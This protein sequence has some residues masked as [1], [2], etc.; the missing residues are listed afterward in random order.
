MNFSQY[1]ILTDLDGTFLHHGTPVPRNIEA[2]R[3]FCEGGGLFSI[4]TGRTHYTV[5]TPLP[6]I[7]ALINLPAVVC[8]GAYLYDYKTGTVLDECFIS[9]S[10]CDELVAFIE[11]H[12]ADVPCRLS[13]PGGIRTPALIG[14][15][16]SDVA[17]NKFGKVT[18]Q[19]LAE[20]QR[21]DWYRLVFHAEREE[22]AE[23]RPKLEACFAGRLE[24]MY[25][26]NRYLE[27]QSAHAHKGAAAKHLHTHYGAG[28]TLIT[29]GD[30]ENDISM[31]RA[32]DISVCP[33]SA[34]EA[35]RQVADYTLCSCEEGLLADV[36][37]R[38][39]LGMLPQKGE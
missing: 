12:A 33:A 27:V 15:V 21:D 3:R 5:R 34:D 16:A 13:V 32:A 24:L 19:P 23:L 4:A 25:S 35:V 10:L 37:E 9:A 26:V 20:W 28:R 29:C 14:G 22:L 38:L 31:L 6:D 30:F 1:M 17:V 18:V 2:V 39:E 11:Q 7:E 8:N 36:I